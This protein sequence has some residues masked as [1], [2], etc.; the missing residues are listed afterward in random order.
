MEGT[1]Y[2]DV[3][4]NLELKLE[5]WDSPNSAGVITDAIRCA[6]LGLDRGLAG[7]LVAPSAVLHEVA[8][9]PDP[10]R[11]RSRPRRG[12]HPRR[13][14]RDARRH[15]EAEGAEDAEGRPSTPAPRRGPQPPRWPRIRRNAVDHP[16]SRSASGPM[17]ALDSLDSSVPAASAAPESAERRT[18]PPTTTAGERKREQVTFW[19]YRN[20]ERLI[21]AVPRRLSMPAAAA[22]GNVAYDLAGSKQRLIAEN[23]SRPM[24][25]PPDDP[26]VRH[27]ARRA[28]R[29]YAKYL[30][31][32][33]RIS[34]LTERGGA[35]PGEHRER[36]DPRGGAHRGTGRA[37]LH[38]AHRRHGHDRTGAEAASGRSCMSSPTTRPTGASTT[39]S[40]RPAPARTSS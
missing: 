18:G 16:A 8:A 2:G 11:H 33:M 4:L 17:K 34:E 10:R 28:F 12:L 24:R 9:A 6:K 23:L 38:R 1:T 20:G 21:R 19:L 35:P 25:L 22:V 30:V 13:G 39:T 14:Q 36:R 37:A 31:D 32:M 7:T 27:A 26:R 29:N 3:P 40:Q 15:R 5:V